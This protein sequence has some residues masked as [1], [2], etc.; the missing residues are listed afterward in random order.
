M[1]G[2]KKKHDIHQSS[3]H[4]PPASQLPKYES[5]ET[6]VGGSRNHSTPVAH[7]TATE[8][9]M[10]S[11][12][13][14]STEEVSIHDKK[15]TVGSKSPSTTTTHART[16]D[17]PIE[18]PPGY[19]KT[20]N[21]PEHAKPPKSTKFKT[22]VHTLERSAVVGP[23]MT[24]SKFDGVQFTTDGGGVFDH[25]QK[26]QFALAEQERKIRIDREAFKEELSEKVITTR[27]KMKAHAV[28]RERR[29][30]K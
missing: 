10:D 23:Q 16:T 5:F 24:T 22:P 3:K 4:E 15:T 25:L 27:K 11:P 30:E 14:Y 2:I 18:P 20:G 28:E 8:I 6:T 29:I 19:T 13:R 21:A 1:A 17:I 26:K 7:A 12:P 9:S